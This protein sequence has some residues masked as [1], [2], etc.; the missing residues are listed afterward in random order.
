MEFLSSQNA[1]PRLEWRQATGSTNADLVALAASEPLP[2]FTVLATANQTAGRGRLDRSWV[3]PPGKALAISVLL[4]PELL[5]SQSLENLSWVP[6]LAGLAVAEALDTSLPT[7]D[8]SNPT[9]VKWPNDVLIGGLKVCGVLSELL[10]NS[11][12]L[13]VGAGINVL[14]TR[15]E[16]PVP[17][18]TSLALAKATLPPQPEAA[19]DLVLAGYLARLKH[20]FDRFVAHG[21]SAETSGLR[22]AVVA[23]CST[24]GAVVS[25]QLPNGTELIGLATGI[26]SSGRLQLEVSGK[27]VAV[28]AGD[29][30]HLR[31]AAQ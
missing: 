29:I 20:W 3:T 1:S 15:E 2:H 17:T 31:A 4:K 24:I 10:P 8:E 16:L 14:Q 28:A 9:S 25:A 19:L 21:L 12:G 7:G 18:A 30:V 26:D 11:Q 22:A 13:V 23:R 5:P 27:P 6:L